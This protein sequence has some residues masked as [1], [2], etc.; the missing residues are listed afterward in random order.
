ML[1]KIY[2]V[3]YTFQGNGYALI[4]A[5]SEDEARMDFE[6]QDRV[7]NDGET[8]ITQ[9]IKSITTISEEK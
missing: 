2:K 9:T 8:T 7:P 6:N 4:E 3:N 5:N 1:K